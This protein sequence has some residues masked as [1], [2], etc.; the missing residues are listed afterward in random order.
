MDEVI[1]WV[2]TWTRGLQQARL[3]RAVTGT[4]SVV[5]G[6][7]GGVVEGTVAKVGGTVGKVSDVLVRQGGLAMGAASGVRFL[8]RGRGRAVAGVGSRGL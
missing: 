1:E 8:P 3:V 4:L 6:K 5:G 7:V 2:R